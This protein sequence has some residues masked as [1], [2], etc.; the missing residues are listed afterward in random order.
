MSRPHQFSIFASSVALTLLAIVACARQ[1]A[2]QGTPEPTPAVE[3]TQEETA[4]NPTDAT[5][6]A[7]ANHSAKNQYRIKV[8]FP[9]EGKIESV[10]RETNS[11]GV[12]KFAIAQLVQGPAEKEK[13]NGLKPAIA[14]QGSS[15]CGAD[16]AIAIEEKIAKLRFCRDVISEKN[17]EVNQA[18]EAT[19]KQFSTVEKVAI[20][21]RNGKCLSTGD[22]SCLEE[23]QPA[24]KLTL[25]GLGGV[26]IGMTITEASQETGIQFVNQSS[27]GEEHGCFYYKAAREPQ[28]VSYMVTEGK[29]ARIEVNTKSITTL[30]GAKIG[31]TEE[32]IKAL[33]PGKI[34][35]EGHE[36]IPGG[37][38]LLFVPEDASNQNYRVVFETNEKGIVTT[39][40]SGK[41]PEVGWI[42][43]CV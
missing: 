34:E 4:N 3:P 43:G 24:N 15:N 37:K 13:Q 16:F 12:A 30:S 27:G 11:Q 7:R 42:E 6:V 32:R 25:T 40:R 36:Y 41:I 8:Y 31:D 23:V 28:D 39:M 20:I 21:D 1:P 5:P 14:L 10:V 19:L 2:K 17:P 29:I 22:N 18:I 9:K 38:Y 35:E 26:E 33:Y